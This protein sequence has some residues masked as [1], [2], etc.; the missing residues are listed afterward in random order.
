M[1]S[2]YSS[3]ASEVNELEMLLADMPV[4]DVLDR[5][6]LESRLAKVKRRLA[7]IPATP[8]S[9][10]VRLTFRGKPVQGIHGIAADFASKA[11]GTFAEAFTAVLASLTESLQSMGPI[12]QRDKRQLL[13]TG[14]AIGSF[15]FEFA[16]PS[17]TETS[18]GQLS[19]LPDDDKPGQAIEAM[20]KLLRH[21]TDGTDDDVAGI[22][23][24]I[25]PRAVKTISK[26]LDLMVQE[27]AWCGLEFGNTSFRYTGHEQIKSAAARIKDDNIREYEESFQ[28]EFQGVLPTARTFEFKSA[29]PEEILR[30][31]VGRAIE[32]PDVLN[33]NWLHKP[34]NAKFTVI[35]VGAKRQ[36]YTLK[37]LTDITL[38]Q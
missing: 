7:E 23:E 26:F 24:E 12:P 38:Q 1:I 2:L 29:V 5:K 30:G 6:S 32:N 8:E 11:A 13:I 15:G 19:L 10:K 16:L 37:S 36:R 14:T 27:E 34:I 18:G 4:E 35:Q 22:V 33:T 31:K 25:Q 17:P 21:A 9:P 28:G 20:E 3:L